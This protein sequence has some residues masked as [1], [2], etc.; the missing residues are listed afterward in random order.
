MEVWNK[1][2]NSMA[3]LPRLMSKKLTSLGIV[4]PFTQH[5]NL[6]LHSSKSDG[7]SSIIPVRQPSRPARPNNLFSNLHPIM[8]FQNRS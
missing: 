1:G 5:S 7:G 8:Q 4:F 3:V 2:Y 6:S